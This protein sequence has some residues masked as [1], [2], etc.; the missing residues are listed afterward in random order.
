MPLYF[1]KTQKREHFD[2]LFKKVK[3]I[4]YWHAIYGKILDLL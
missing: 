3:L 1:T 2:C 4:K